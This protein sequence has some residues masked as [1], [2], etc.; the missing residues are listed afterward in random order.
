MNS[1]YFSPRECGH[2]LRFRPIHMRYDNPYEG[3]EIEQL[4]SKD[5]IRNLLIPSQNVSVYPV[6]WHKN[7][8]L[9]L[10]NKA[11]VSI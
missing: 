9:K 11:K 6:I 7:E 4:V 2:L 8:Y 1:F 10:Q 3:K 5:S